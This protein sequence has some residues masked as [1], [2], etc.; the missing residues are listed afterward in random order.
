M[1][2]SLTTSKLRKH[3]AIEPAISIK[4]RE[5]NVILSSA[6]T[7]IYDWLK[8]Q[9][10]Y[11]PVSPVLA[12]MNENPFADDVMDQITLCD[13]DE[14]GNTY[15][16]APSAW[17]PLVEQPHAELMLIDPSLGITAS[18]S[19]P[20]TSDAIVTVPEQFVEA[21]S[22]ILIYLAQVLEIPDKFNSAANPSAEMAFTTEELETLE[23]I[24]EGNLGTITPSVIDG[25][26]VNLNPQ[27]ADIEDVIDHRRVGPHRQTFY[28]AKSDNGSYYW[29]YPGA[30]RDRHLRKLI[31]DYRHKIQAE[32]ESRKA[33]SARKLRNGKL[34]GI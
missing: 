5:R 12:P 6:M 17:K 1:T 30:N 23:P 8:N 25:V 11:A 15:F 19:M 34:I 7:D 29:F 28:L 24:P 3:S 10:S 14:N 13:I 2:M 33:R 27:F 16:D 32:V 20:T 21:S 26:C 9:P 22:K 18:S 31:G 4:V